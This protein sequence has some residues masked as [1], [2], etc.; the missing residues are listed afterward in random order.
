[1]NPWMLILMNKQHK[2]PGIFTM[3]AL[4]YSICI[5]LSKLRIAIADNLSYN[6]YISFYDREII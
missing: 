6:I 3:A 1:M 2:P 4:I 5:N